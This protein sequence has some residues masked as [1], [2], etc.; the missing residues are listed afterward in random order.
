MATNIFSCGV[1]LMDEDLSQKPNV[2]L[3][4]LKKLGW[5]LLFTS[6]YWVFWI[7]MIRFGIPLLLPLAICCNFV[8]IIKRMC[9]EAPACM[10]CCFFS[11]VFLA[12]I[13]QYYQFNDIIAP[14]I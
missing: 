1:G 5:F 3:Q 12:P 11:F 4:Y 9:G 6:G 8:A 10:G 13:K 7:L 14:G 2:C